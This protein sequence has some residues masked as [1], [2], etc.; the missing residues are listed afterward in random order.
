MQYRE[1]VA[2]TRELSWQNV[3]GDET[4]RNSY[5]RANQLVELSPKLNLGNTKNTDLKIKLINEQDSK[6]CR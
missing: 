3:Q 5:T 6:H 4:R 1:S 2:K